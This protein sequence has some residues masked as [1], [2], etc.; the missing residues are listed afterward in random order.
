M[1]PTCEGTPPSIEMLF[2]FS[3]YMLDHSTKASPLYPTVQQVSVSNRK[4]RHAYE[5]IYFMF[6][7]LLLCNSFILWSVKLSWCLFPP[8]F[9]H[10]PFFLQLTFVWNSNIYCIFIRAALLELSVLETKKKNIAIVTHLFEFTLCLILLLVFLSLLVTCYS[11]ITT[12]LF[13]P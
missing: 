4:R 1:R 11:V 12:V 6:L 13:A 5:H 3:N 7:S 2:S 10:W 9:F 8:L